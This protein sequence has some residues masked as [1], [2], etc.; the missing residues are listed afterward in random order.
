MFA[1]FEPYNAAITLTWAQHLKQGKAMSAAFP[2]NPFESSH[3][4]DK[5]SRF[6]YKEPV[7]PQGHAQERQDRLTRKQRKGL[8]LLPQSPHRIP[9]SQKKGIELSEAVE[10]FERLEL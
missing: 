10:R 9:E 8:R 5:C 1:L 4:G 3:P 6:C 2:S 7:C